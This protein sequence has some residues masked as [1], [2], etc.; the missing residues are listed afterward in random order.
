MY[1]VDVL[2]QD[3]CYYIY[4]QI[5]IL[6][7]VYDHILLNFLQALLLA[8]FFLKEN[9]FY[10]KSYETPF[11]NHT[12][13]HPSMHPKVEMYYEYRMGEGMWQ[14]LVCWWL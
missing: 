12:R 8:F 13:M 7:Y 5:I 2:L 14:D 9:L 3:L 10:E 11:K 6:Y 1:V 4:I